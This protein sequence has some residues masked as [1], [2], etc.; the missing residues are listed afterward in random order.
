[1][2]ALW[3]GAAVAW[4][5]RYSV[6]DTGFVDLGG[7]GYRLEWVVPGGFPEGARRDAMAAASAMLAE[8]NVR[9]EWGAARVGDG[10]TLRMVDG[11]GRVLELGPAEA[12]ED[13]FR[14]LDRAVTSPARERLLRECLR[15]YAVVVIV[16]GTEDALNARAVATARAAVEEVARRIPGMPK[17]VDVPPQVMVVPRSEVASERVLVWGLGL[18]PG[19]AAEPRL[20]LVYGRGRRLGTPLEGPLITATTL[21]ERLVLVGQD[22]ECDLDREWLRGPLVPARWDAAMQQVASKALGFDPE[23]PMIRAEVSRIVERGPVAGQKRKMA[24]T[25][26]ALGYAEETV[27]GMGDGVGQAG[28]KE[29]GSVAGGGHVGTRMGADVKG[30]RPATWAWALVGAA[31]LAVVMAGGW[32]VWRGGRG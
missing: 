15:A 3:M 4:A 11:Q 14:V 31:G 17:P 9:L 24:G 23:N 18:E 10:P 19:E 22:C 5:C 20:A 8:S 32:I 6:R 21:R 1:M 13:P 30:E 12:G 2:L 25:S 16:E 28:E 29:E 27:E 7:G 26:Q